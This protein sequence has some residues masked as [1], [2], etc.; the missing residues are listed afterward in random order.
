MNL[1][2]LLNWFKPAKPKRKYNLDDVRSTLEQRL[3]V[4]D[5]TSDEFKHI[6]W[7]LRD[8]AY[9]YMKTRGDYETCENLLNLVIE[10]NPLDTNA[11]NDL[12]LLELR[13]KNFD[14]AR[15]YFIK[16]I[17]LN[18]ELD[19]AYE[20]LF[21]L[22]CLMGQETD[23]ERDREKYWLLAIGL[24]E[25]LGVPHNFDKRNARTIY[26]SLACLYEEQFAFHDSINLF[27]KALDLTD[28]ISER[29]TL[30]LRIT[31][32]MARIHLDQLR[33]SL[34]SDDLQEESSS[35]GVLR[36]F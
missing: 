36:A 21:I 23:N 5:K 34:D 16:S 29:S 4:A 27:Q 22:Y 3:A 2:A 14:K 32:C 28:D 19:Y 6:L 1:K 17:K 12:G 26:Y 9:Y 15:G 18:P 7:D 8:V 13:R 20:N 31:G 30:Q 25:K 33:A 10:N 24:Y 11:Y 35:G